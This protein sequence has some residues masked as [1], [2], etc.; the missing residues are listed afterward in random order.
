MGDP[1]N[2]AECSVS[3]VSLTKTRRGYI[4]KMRHTIFN[5]FDYEYD[6]L[7]QRCY[8]RNPRDLLC[9]VTMLPPSRRASDG[10]TEVQ[11]FG[12]QVVRRRMVSRIVRPF[13]LVVSCV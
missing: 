2:W 8:M 7:H 9:K 4:Y 11:G 3:R 10:V 6:D 13:R 5:N 1:V 12:R